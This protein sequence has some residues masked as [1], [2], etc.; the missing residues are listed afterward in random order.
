MVVQLI[1]LTKHNTFGDP[2]SPN[3]P[4]VNV[5]IADHGRFYCYMDVA[6]TLSW[7]KKTGWVSYKHGKIKED[8]LLAYLG[9]LK[10]ESERLGQVCRIRARVPADAP[11]RYFV[12]LAK[13]MEQVGVEEF[14]VAT[15]ADRSAWF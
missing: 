14:T 5:P 15:R 2:L 4:Y 1:W 6:D 3:Y 9:Y 8:G 13:S 10:S 7:T 12:Y 11:A